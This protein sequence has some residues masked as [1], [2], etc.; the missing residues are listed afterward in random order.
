MAQRE[1]VGSPR[2]TGSSAAAASS[3]IDSD[4]DDVDLVQVAPVAQKQPELIS[5]GVSSLITGPD[6]K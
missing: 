5:K 1:G 2:P 3:V 6:T 4:S